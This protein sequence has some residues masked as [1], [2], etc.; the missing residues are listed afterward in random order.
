MEFVLRQTGTRPV[1]GKDGVVQKP[2]YESVED[3]FERHVCDV[4]GVE[5]TKTE[6]TMEVEIPSAVKGGKPTRATAKVL[7]LPD[8]AHKICTAAAE[9]FNAEQDISY[10][11][12]YGHGYRDKTENKPMAT[13]GGS[14]GTT[15]E[16]ERFLVEFR[17]VT[18]PL[19]DGESI[20]DLFKQALQHK[21]DLGASNGY[22]QGYKDKAGGTMPKFQVWENPKEEASKFEY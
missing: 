3:A 4:L 5:Y 17:S 11:L 20:F 19:P 22:W 1:H 2:V 6:R 10:R 13:S 9:F 21:R 14:L 12:G 7:C 16:T 15:H 8:P 18:K